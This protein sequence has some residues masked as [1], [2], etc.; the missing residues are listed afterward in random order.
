VVADSPTGDKHNSPIVTK[1][2][3]PISHKGLANVFVPFKRPGIV[4]NKNEQPA[5]NIPIV[6][7]IGVD[8]CLSPS[9]AHNA[10]KTGAKTTINMGLT[11]WN[12]P[13]SRVIPK[14]SSCVR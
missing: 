5:K 10:A 8:G 3:K 7:L 6:N 13:G 1:K 4:N 14:K 11:D 12:Q 9:F 2:K